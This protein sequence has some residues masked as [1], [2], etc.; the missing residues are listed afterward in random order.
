MCLSNEIVS[1]A[2]TFSTFVAKLIVQD[3]GTC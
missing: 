2:L 1:I 3:F